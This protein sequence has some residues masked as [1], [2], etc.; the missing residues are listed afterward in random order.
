MPRVN[1]ALRAAHEGGWLAEFDSLGRPSEVVNT[2]QLRPRHEPFCGKL[3][4]AAFQAS[5]ANLVEFIRARGN[6]RPHLAD[7]VS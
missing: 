2:Y 5:E 3:A 6:T 4:N 7:L 1:V